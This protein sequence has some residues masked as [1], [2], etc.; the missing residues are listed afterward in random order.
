MY[1]YVIIGA[2]S[3]G[4]VLANRLTE[5][6]NTTVLLLEAGNSDQKQ[7]IHIPAGFHKLFKTEYD[8]AYYTEPQ[9]HLNNRQLYWPRGKVI[10]GSSSINAM[11]YIRGNWRDYDDWQ[12][13]GN[14]GWSA[15]DVLPY[16]I[17]AENQNVLKNAYHGVDGLLN[18][19][20]QRCIN[21][22][23][24]AFVKAGQQAGFSLN[25]DFNG[26]KQ[27]GVGFYQVTQKEGRRHSVAA[28]YLKPIL[29]RS[30]LTIKTNSQVTKI[31]FSGN[32]VFGLTYIHNQV[33]HEIKIA[34]EIILSA[35]AINSPQ[36]LMLSGIGDAENLKSLGIPVVINLSGVGKNLQ[37][38]LCVPVAYKCTQSISLA[39]AEKFRNILKY[40]VLKNGPLT[41]NVA[42]AGGFVKIHPDLA[43][44]DLQFHF[45]PVFFLNHGFIR[46]E[47]HG[48]TFGAT[49]LYPQSKG[50]INLRS[51]NPLEA[52]IIQ[53]NYLEKEADLEVLV[54]GVKL[55][56]QLAKMPA[57]DSY[58]GEELVPGLQVQNDEE[59][60]AYIR[61]TVESLYHPVGTCKMGNDSMAVVNSQL[62]VHG[63]QGLR[64]VDAS[65][66]PSIIGGN[67]NAPTIMIAEKAADLIKNS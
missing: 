40:V 9:S 65:I 44:S 29:R 28:A 5:D 48:F 1:D 18:V 19:T 43:R 11:I 32:K 62:Q 61:D 23:S 13:L 14:L 27:E 51:I 12:E 31:N 22:L 6:P 46:P 35:G 47:G 42:E 45:A 10:G 34:K 30:N 52:P 67:T 60:R 56:R 59:I 39:N 2:G 50:S 3:A 63:V 38:H 66:M 53:P 21:L 15:K 58:R 4:C 8:W 33:R 41:T 7:E 17:Q 49:L 37:D 57:F 26:A 36:L 25:Y 16:F 64:V 20:N 54:A 24:H 55:S